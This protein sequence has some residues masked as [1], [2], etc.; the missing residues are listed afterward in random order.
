[1]TERQQSLDFG[2]AHLRHKQHDA[3]VDER[4]LEHL[5]ELNRNFVDLLGAEGRGVRDGED[6]RD[7]AANRRDPRVVNLDSAQRSILAD[8]PFSL[9]NARFQEGQFWSGVSHGNAGNENAAK[10]SYRHTGE[11][12]LG[13]FTEMVLFYACRFAIAIAPSAITRMMAI[14]VSHARI[15]FCRE[16]APVMNGEA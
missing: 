11:S 10:L 12:F 8:C 2:S 16:A 15:L 3:P 13:G 14:G 5:R 1:M 9:F 4:V 6:T 7:E